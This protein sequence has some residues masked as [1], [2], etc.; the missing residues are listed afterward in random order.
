V[1]P[2]AAE[3]DQIFKM[4]AEHARHQPVKNQARLRLQARGKWNADVTKAAGIA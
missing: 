3:R 2:S 4:S 1:I